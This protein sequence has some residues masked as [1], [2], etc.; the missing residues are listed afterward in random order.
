MQMGHGG[1]RYS[2]TGWLTSITLLSSDG[3]GDRKLAFK[4]VVD[5]LE[6]RGSALISPA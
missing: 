6:N 5:Q 4:E 3:L 2:G 1:V